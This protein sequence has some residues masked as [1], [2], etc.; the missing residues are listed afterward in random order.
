VAHNYINAAI[1]YAALAKLTG[2]IPKSLMRMLG[3]DGN[4]TAKNLLGILDQVK[5]QEGVDF[6]ARAKHA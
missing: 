3:P 4:P 6:E 1:G 5:K 2:K